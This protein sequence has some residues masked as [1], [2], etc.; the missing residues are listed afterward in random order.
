MEQETKRKIRQ[1]ETK[2]ANAINNQKLIE[3][4]DEKTRK[5][6]VANII[7][8]LIAHLIGTVTFPPICLVAIIYNCL[9]VVTFGSVIMYYESKEAK[10]E[11][12]IKTCDD[13]INKLEGLLKSSQLKQIPTVANNQTK[14]IDDKNLNSSHP[15][16]KK[17]K[18]L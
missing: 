8:S 4:K 12:E 13:E 18:K 17:S 2:R 9:N 3:A 14:K 15:Q 1:Y 5:Y 10:L 6:L 16:P 11:K 7:A